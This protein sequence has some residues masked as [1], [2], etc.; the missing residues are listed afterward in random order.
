M[1]YSGCSQSAGRRHLNRYAAVKGNLNNQSR[2]LG[3]Y[4]SDGI[5]LQTSGMVKRKAA[6]KGFLVMPMAT[7]PG[8]STSTATAQLPF[9]Q[10]AMQLGPSSSS[11]SRM[12]LMQCRRSEGAG[13]F[14]YISH[15]GFLVLFHAGSHHSLVRPF[16]AVNKFGR[17]V[18][19][20]A[21][22]ISTFRAESRKG[23]GTMATAQG[24]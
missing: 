22:N 12:P 7:A 23:S 5:R 9:H 10:E 17:Q 6:L 24:Q 11:I 14:A 8:H 1:V 21:E 19:G 4:A 3:A 2:G 15:V 13:H 20:N 18:I 16:N